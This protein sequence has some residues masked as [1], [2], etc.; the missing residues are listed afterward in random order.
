MYL[1]IETVVLVLGTVAAFTLAGTVMLV[2][3]VLL[4]WFGQARAHPSSISGSSEV[5]SGLPAD[6]V[7]DA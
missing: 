2:V 5:P 6:T 4:S 1:T 3:G 7:T